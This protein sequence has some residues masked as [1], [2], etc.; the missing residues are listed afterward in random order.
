MQKYCQ[1]VSIP[2]ANESPIYL[3]SDCWNK[4]L[5]YTHDSAS[6]ADEY[7]VQL[8]MGLDFNHKPTALGLA[9]V[10]LFGFLLGGFRA[11]WLFHR[12]LGQPAK[13]TIAADREYHNWTCV[14][15]I[16]RLA[17]TPA[18]YISS[19]R[20]PCCKKVEMQ[21][22]SKNAGHLNFGRDAFLSR[23]PSHSCFTHNLVN[24]NCGNGNYTDWW[25][26]TKPNE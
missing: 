22:S 21:P 15:R 3:R 7:E 16:A 17:A 5:D 10:S 4:I 1:S 18:S 24:D 12:V 14:F 25:S 19:N 11:L 23:S 6:R 20:F 8:L 2:E 9:V 13:W 26:W